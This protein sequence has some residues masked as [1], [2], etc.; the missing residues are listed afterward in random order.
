MHF[1]NVAAVLGFTAGLAVAAPLSPNKAGVVDAREPQ[2]YGTV[3]FD[4]MMATDI[5]V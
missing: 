1:L 2:S 4:F 3:N 5:D